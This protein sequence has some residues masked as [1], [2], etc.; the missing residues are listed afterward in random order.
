MSNSGSLVPLTPAALDAFRQA[1][2]EIIRR[3]VA[4]SME[5][6]DQVAHHGQEAQ[7]LLTSGIEFTT[8]MLDSAMTVGHGALLE[9]QMTWAQDRLPHDGVE[10]EHLLTRFK[11]YE[12]VV[13]ELLPAEVAAQVNAYLQWMIARQKELLGERGGGETLA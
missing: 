5:H 11:I 12:D 13:G 1:R 8:R 2:P 7:R 4:R 10:P 9:D 6:E 3:V